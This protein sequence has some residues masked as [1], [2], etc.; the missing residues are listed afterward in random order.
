[1]VFEWYSTKIAEIWKIFRIFNRI[2]KMLIFRIKI[3]V[4]TGCGNKA[5]FRTDKHKVWR[6]VFSSMSNILLIHLLIKNTLFFF[7]ENILSVQNFYIFAIRYISFLVEDLS[8]TIESILIFQKMTH[9]LNKILLVTSGNKTFLK[10]SRKYSSLL[11]HSSYIYPT[12]T[13]RKSTQQF[14]QSKTFQK[15]FPNVSFNFS[16]FTGEFFSLQKR[17]IPRK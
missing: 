14:S 3:A 1:M 15:F 17:N 13:K 6:D 4:E 8:C 7:R 16:S 5:N 10:Y 2:T 9:Y 12:Q 11:S